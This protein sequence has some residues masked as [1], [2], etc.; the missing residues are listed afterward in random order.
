MLFIGILLYMLLNRNV[1]VSAVLLRV[2][3]LQQIVSEN[4]IVRIVRGYGA[5]ML[6]SASFT[7]IIQ[8]IVWFPKKKTALLINCSLLGITYEILQYIGFVNGVAD[9]IDAVVY[10]FGSLFAILIILGGKY[11]EEE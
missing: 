7:M 2:L 6:W 8:F 1:L 3:P 9:P 10:I 4:L 11:Y 5:D